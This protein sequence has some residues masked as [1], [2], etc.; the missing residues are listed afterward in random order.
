MIDY[1]FQ[2]KGIPVYVDPY[3]KENE[4]LKG[5]KEN[6]EYFLIIS[7]KIANKLIQENR[8]KKLERIC[9]LKLC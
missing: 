8:R 4:I 6:K 2:W 1:K 9:H 7:D 3:M 5:R